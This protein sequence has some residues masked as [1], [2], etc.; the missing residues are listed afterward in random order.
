LIELNIN[1]DH[2]AT[3]RNARGEV[4]PDPFNAALLSINN[5]ADGIVCHLREDRRHI[6]DNDVIKLREL[7]TRLDLEMA[8]S[9]DIVKLALEVKPDL[10]TIVPEKREEL[11][12]EGGLNTSFKLNELKILTERFHDK[13]IIVSLFI[14]PNIININDTLEIKAD[15]VEF[16]TGHY[17][18]ETHNKDYHLDLIKKSVDYAK[19]NNLRVAAGHG[20]DY[21]NTSEIAKIK[22]IDELSIGHSVIS[23]SIFVGIP[24]AVKQMKDIIIDAV[25]N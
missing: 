11:T 1:I 5:G 22:G 14:E 18:N 8:T 4:E 17:A 25:K 15:M 13:G 21:N 7:D 16:H 20:L 23:K 24:T 3:V 6:K 9:E 12:T 2:V 10:V 19:K